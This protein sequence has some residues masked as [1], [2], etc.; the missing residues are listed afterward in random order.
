MRLSAT[1]QEKVLDDSQD[2]LSELAVLYVNRFCRKVDLRTPSISSDMVLEVIKTVAMHFPDS[3]RTGDMERDWVSRA[4]EHVSPSDARALFHEATSYGMIEKDS[5][6]TWRWRHEFLCS[7][8]A[9]SG[10]N[11]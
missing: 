10:G 11:D 9:S 7:S 6:T 8:L 3:N 4:C 2:G 5:T 1:N